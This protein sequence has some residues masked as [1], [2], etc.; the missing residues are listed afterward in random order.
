MGRPLKVDRQEVI[1]VVVALRDWL[2]VDH[3]A[4]LA[5]HRRKAEVIRKAI[6]G[7]PHVT[8]V[9]SPDERGLSSGVRVTLDEQGLG[10]T[11]AQVIQALR[12][13]SPGIWTRGG[14]NG[15]QIATSPMADGEETIVAERL[16]E[17][18]GK[19]S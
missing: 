18:L 12:Q 17:V 3:E 16:R 15:F 5:E 4:R 1:G 13:G 9:W 8:A 11:A 14:G 6:A 2:V 10:R 19:N 7:L